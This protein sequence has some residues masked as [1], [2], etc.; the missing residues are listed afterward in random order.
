MELFTEFK[1]EGLVA[2]EQDITD[3][4]GVIGE[5]LHAVIVRIDIRKE[6]TF[7]AKKRCNPGP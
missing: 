5:L 6:V 1:E 7:L 2:S 3:Y 4:K